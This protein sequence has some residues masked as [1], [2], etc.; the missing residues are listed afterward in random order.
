MLNFVLM[1]SVFCPRCWS[2]ASPGVI[3]S[4]IPGLY[5]EQWRHREIL[6]END[7][8]S[9]KIS[10]AHVEE[11]DENDKAK[12]QGWI[13]YYACRDIT[14][15]LTRACARITRAEWNSCMWDHF[16]FDHLLNPYLWMPT[17]EKF[18]KYV[19]NAT[20]GKKCYVLSP[21]I[22]ENVFDRPAEVFHCFDRH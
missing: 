12:R 4:V 1:R 16:L 20:H 5:H 3:G 11:R 2:G 6:S 9:T 13:T 17:K 14:C 21:G 22:K 7:T 19:R 8:I 15:L 18:Y 10:S